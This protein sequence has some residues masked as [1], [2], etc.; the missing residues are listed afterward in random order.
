MTASSSSGDADMPGLDRLWT[1]WRNDYVTTGGA[2]TPGS[3]SVFT[4]IL[5]SDLPDEESLILHRGAQ[6][7]AILNRFPYSTG[8]LMVLP[9]REIPDLEDLSGDEST[10]L[11]AIVTD[12]VRAIKVALQPHGINVG[13]NLGRAAGGSVAQHLHVHAVPRWTG[14][15]NFMSATA[16]TRTIPE[17]LPDTWAKV[18]SAW[19]TR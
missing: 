1:G 15:A 13:I 4:R 8:H 10:E 7:F 17:A 5:A 3:A 9:Y 6:C 12:A 16:W 11:W 2:G 18:R 19:P 14:D